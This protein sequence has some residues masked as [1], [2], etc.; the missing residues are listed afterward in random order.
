MSA[1]RRYSASEGT[2]DYKTTHR[3]TTTT[4]HPA[5]ALDFAACVDKLS[6]EEALDLGFTSGPTSS[7]HL[8]TPS[9]CL[10]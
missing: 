9:S 7:A 4:T 5:M 1:V 3:L 8:T 6:P 2:L 10:T